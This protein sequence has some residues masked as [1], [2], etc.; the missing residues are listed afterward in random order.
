MGE[1]RIPEHTQYAT[2]LPRLFAHAQH[3]R[4]I[5]IGIGIG[6]ENRKSGI[7]RNFSRWLQRQG[8]SRIAA[9]SQPFRAARRGAARRGATDAGKMKAFTLWKGTKHASWIAHSERRKDMSDWTGIFI[10][11]IRKHTAVHFHREYQLRP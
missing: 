2:F 11:D 10:S 3:Y 4:G 8:K 6:A 5:G 1:S 9:L 7:P